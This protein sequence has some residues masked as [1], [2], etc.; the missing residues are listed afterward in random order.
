MAYSDIADAMIEQ[1]NLKIE[2]P[3]YYAKWMISDS[4]QEGRYMELIM[5]ELHSIA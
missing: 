3:H 5:R 1:Y 4:P 2:R